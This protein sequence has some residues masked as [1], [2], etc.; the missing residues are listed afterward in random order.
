MQDLG[1][2]KTITGTVGSVKNLLTGGGG[3]VCC[4]LPQLP[5]RRSPFPLGV[6]ALLSRGHKGWFVPD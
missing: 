4:T 1:I 2:M 5:R 3:N 6:L